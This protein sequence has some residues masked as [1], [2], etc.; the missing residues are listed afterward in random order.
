MT[1]RE[2]EV[3]SHQQKLKIN[4]PDCSYPYVWMQILII[5]LKIKY[6]LPKKEEENIAVICCKR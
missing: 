2:K 1:A 5:F 3:K 4:R 6:T